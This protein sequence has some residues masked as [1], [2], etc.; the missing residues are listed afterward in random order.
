MKTEKCFENCKR[1]EPVTFYDPEIN[2]VTVSNDYYEITHLITPFQVKALVD[3]V[4]FLLFL[5]FKLSRDK[6]DRYKKG[7]AIPLLKFKV[8]LKDE[9]QF[10][11]LKLSFRGTHLMMEYVIPTYDLQQQ[12]DPT[13]E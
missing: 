1:K 5:L 8:S 10:T 13:S 9:N 2:E 3:V 4:K 7:K 11:D 12:Q 6:V